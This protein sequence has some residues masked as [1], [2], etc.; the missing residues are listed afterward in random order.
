[1]SR[2]RRLVAATALTVL[3]A[4][5]ANCSSSSDAPSPP[6]PGTLQRG[7]AAS[8]DAAADAPVRDDASSFPDVSDAGADSGS[9]ADGGVDACTSQIAVVGGTVSG[10]STIAFAATLARGGSWAVSSLPS[11]VASPPAI[12]A[13]SGGFIVAFV[14]DAN[15]LEFATSTWTWSSPA[16]ITGMSVL[17]SPSLAVVGTSVH[18]VYQGPDFKYVHGIYTASAGWDAADD[19]IGG[20][21]SQGFGPGA[22]V[23]ASVDGALVVAYGGQDGSLYDETWTAGA[24]EPPN[25]HAAAQM[26]ALSP[27]LAALKGGSSD[28]LVVYADPLGTLY[29]TTRT[30]GTWSTPAIVNA[31]AFSDDPPS[32]AS[33]PGGRAMM[34]YLGTNGLPYFSLYDPAATPSWTSP[35]AIGTGSTMLL[36]PPAVAP[37]VCEDDA[38]VALVEPAG[39][40]TIGYAGGTWLPEALLGGTAGMTFAAVASQP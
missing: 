2:M 11:N 23:A 7:D 38:I 24:W 25:Q 29:S 40:A 16:N 35:A 33:L 19:P 13:F 14:D 9:S 34:T 18:V 15:E 32:L 10:A 8:S 28:A 26:G 4:G 27:S 1:M 36:S 31:A 20:A 37:G 3:P 39:V 21:D 22:P 12:A 5:L 30:A 6:K 17:G